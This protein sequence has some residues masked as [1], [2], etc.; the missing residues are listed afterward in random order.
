MVNDL[1][2]SSKNPTNNFRFKNCLF[3][4]NNIVK[5]TDKEK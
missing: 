3:C 2:A 4:R 5:N 1:D